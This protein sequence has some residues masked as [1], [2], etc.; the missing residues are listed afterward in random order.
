MPFGICSAPEIFQRRIHELIVGLMGVEVVAD[1]FVVVGRGHT[2]AEAIHD[3]DKNLQALLQ[4]WEK[5]G[6]RL[7]ADK[8]RLQMHEVPFIGH[9]AT[10]HGLCVDPAEVQAI[11]GNAH[12]QGCDI[13]TEIVGTSTVP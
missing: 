3:H 13:S 7:N 1:D 10:D 9:M 5:Q 6:V 8:L 11:Q 4:R 2:E 12:T